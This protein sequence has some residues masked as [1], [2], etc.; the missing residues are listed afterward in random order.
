M[1][2]IRKNIV[3]TGLSGG[4]EKKILIKDYGCR[5][6]M[7]AFPDRSNVEMSPQQIKSV[8]RFREAMVYAKTQMAD[9]ISKAEYKN[10][11]RD[12]QRP[13][14]LAVADFLNPPEIHAIEL[15][16]FKGCSGDLVSIHATDDF[17]VVRVLLEVFDHLNQLLEKGDAVCVAGK[18]QYI[19]QNSYK[20]THG[21]RFVAKAWD[22]PGNCAE[23]M[24]AI[25]DGI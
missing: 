1:P 11:A 3:L 23:L 15:K 13:H 21:M 4:I 10:K 14:N 20:Q 16:W 7:S 9:P 22:K 19:L 24:V 2:K 12:M 8:N 5:S 17:K 25:T 18:W 6:V